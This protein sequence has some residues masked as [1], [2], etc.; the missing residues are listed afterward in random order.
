[1]RLRNPQQ[2]QRQVLLLVHTVILRKSKVS[3]AAISPRSRASLVHQLD[4]L[5]AQRLLMDQGSDTG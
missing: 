4:I 5:R 2:K 3:T 1:M